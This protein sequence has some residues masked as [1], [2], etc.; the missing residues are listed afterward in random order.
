MDTSFYRSSKGRL[1]F[2]LGGRID[3]TDFWVGLVVIV[4]QRLQFFSTANV[5]AEVLSA[6]FLLSSL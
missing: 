6:N 4:G 2:A 5:S 1:L 3:R